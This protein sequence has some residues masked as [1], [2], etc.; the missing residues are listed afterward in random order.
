V[1]RPLIQHPPDPISTS[2]A[3]GAT[4][5]SA[6][7]WGW[8]SGGDLA[9]PVDPRAGVTAGRRRAQ[10]GGGQSGQNQCAGHQR[11]LEREGQRGSIMPVMR[12]PPPLGHSARWIRAPL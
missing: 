5:T 2:M 9:G 12:A 3:T 8:P 11:G 6:G 7:G 10:S 1:P 4:S